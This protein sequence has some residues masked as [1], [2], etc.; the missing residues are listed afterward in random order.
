MKRHIKLRDLA[1]LPCKP[2]W[3][4]YTKEELDKARAVLVKRGLRFDNSSGKI[5]DDKIGLLESYVNPSDFV[6]HESEEDVMEWEF[7]RYIN[8]EAFRMRSLGR[9]YKY[10]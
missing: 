8:N 1:H 2:S 4:T 5:R 6:P 3:R 7:S 9:D 10:L